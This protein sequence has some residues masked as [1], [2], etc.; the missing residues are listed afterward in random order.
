MYFENYKIFLLFC[1]HVT[2][3]LE[4]FKCYY[5]LLCARNSVHLKYLR[6]FKQEKIETREFYGSEGHMI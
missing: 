4:A 5:D 1:K 2:F 6:Y 3:D